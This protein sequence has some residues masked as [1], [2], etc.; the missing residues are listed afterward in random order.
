MRKSNDMASADPDLAKTAVSREVQHS[1]ALNRYSLL[2]ARSKMF[3][4]LEADR[5]ANYIRKFN[6]PFR[7][8]QF[9]LHY[10]NQPNYGV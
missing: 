9:T 6:S 3:W 10:K 1:A 7:V 5:N 4:R 8:N 2:I